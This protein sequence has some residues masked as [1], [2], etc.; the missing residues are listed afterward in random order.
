VE[1]LD[2]VTL[3]EDLPEEGLRAGSTGTIVHVFDRPQRAYEV[4]F[5][6]ED[7]STIATAALLP[8]QIKP[9]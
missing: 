9:A 3:V 1:L 2:V 4:E 8:G 6:D 7:G 5:L